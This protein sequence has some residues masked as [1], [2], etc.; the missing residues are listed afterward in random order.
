MMLVGVPP[1]EAA[2]FISGVRLRTPEPH[3]ARP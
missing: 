3:E 1:G 2:H